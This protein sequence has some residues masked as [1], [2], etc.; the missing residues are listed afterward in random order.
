MLVY[1]LFS[2]I[3][4]LL[5]YYFIISFEPYKNYKNETNMTYNDYIDIEKNI[6]SLFDNKDKSLSLKYYK[7]VP[8]NMRWKIHRWSMWDYLPSLDY[9]YHCRIKTYHGNDKC[10]PISNKE[11]CSIDNLYKTKFECLNKKIN[12]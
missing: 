9:P 10:V 12:I 2:I 7:S 1:L 11:Y 4:A 3:I 5:S 6:M 8:K